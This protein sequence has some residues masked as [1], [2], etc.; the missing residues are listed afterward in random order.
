[1]F[2]I[3][4]RV[5]GAAAEALGWQ[6]FDGDRQLIANVFGGLCP[7]EE[8]RTLLAKLALRRTDDSGRHAYPEPG[9]LIKCVRELLD[10][11][12]AVQVFDSWLS[13]AKVSD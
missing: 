13:A 8:C 12:F 7:A 3:C 4:R 6:L 10:A 5:G 9:A 1:M 2:R 11:L